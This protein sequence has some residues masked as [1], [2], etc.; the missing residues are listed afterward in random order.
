MTSLGDVRNFMEAHVFAVWDFMSLLKRLQRD[1]TCVQVPWIPVGNADVRHLV[2]EIVAG[3]ESDVDAEGRRT[4]HFE[5]YVASMAESGARTA[6]I[7][8]AVEAVRRGA[9]PREALGSP[10][11]PAH[12]RDFS[13][14]TFGLATHGGTHEVAAAFTFGREDL[15]PDLFHGLVE[16]L[17]HEHPGRL[18]TFRYYLQRHID[19]DGGE[20]GGLA[21]RMVEAVCGAD[22]ARWLE[23]AQAAEAAIE[24][25]LRLWDG[26]TAAMESSVPM[27]LQSAAR[28]LAGVGSR[29]L[30]FC[31]RILG[32]HGSLGLGPKGHH[33]VA[34]SEIPYR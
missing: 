19:V 13:T 24:A 14:T 17:S 10:A 23:A 34:P 5:L 27:D 1:L 15:I 31:E 2:N 12:A 30:S 11:I 8:A 6:P 21:L 3:E 32:E 16:R 29:V 4:S 26:V 20:H 25:R 18:A 9:S 7:L 28:R 22:P 33:E